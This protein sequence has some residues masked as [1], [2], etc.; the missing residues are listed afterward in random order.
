MRI[1]TLSETEINPAI[2]AAIR[3]SLCLVF[4]DDI[5][6][7]SQTRAW[8]GSIPS[9]SHIIEVDGKIIAHVSVIDRH[10]LIGDHPLH[11]AGIQNIFVLPD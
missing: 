3:K 9:W 2:D 8:H 7:F 10:I 5:S 11:I 6:V 1:T 4:S